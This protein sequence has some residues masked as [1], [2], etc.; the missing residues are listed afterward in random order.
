MQTYLN[1]SGQK[2][3]NKPT[4]KVLVLTNKHTLSPTYRQKRNEVLFNIKNGIYTFIY[5]KA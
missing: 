5:L 4:K 2:E 3:K 1:C